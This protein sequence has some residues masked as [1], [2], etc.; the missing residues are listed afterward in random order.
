MGIEAVTIIGI[1]M[2][3]AMGFLGRRAAEHGA[4]RQLW[5]TAHFALCF[6]VLLALIY[7]NFMLAKTGLD[8]IIGG[9][10]PYTVKAGDPIGFVLL[11]SGKAHITPFLAL[12]ITI[13]SIMAAGKLHR[14]A[15]RFLSLIRDGG[16]WSEKLIAGVWITALPIVLLFDSALLGFRIAMMLAPEEMVGGFASMPALSTLLSRG[17]A[18][19]QVLKI[20]MPGYVGVIFVVESKASSTWAEFLE[21]FRGVGRD[22]LARHRAETAVVQLEPEPDPIALE[23]NGRLRLEDEDIENPERFVRPVPGAR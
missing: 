2:I 6:A 11:G 18:V 16:H 9:S 4:D 22:E 5:A 17:D 10:E 19:S 21:A 12:V 1:L 14:Q 15:R 20:F 8:R 3:A 7:T 13:G 23:E